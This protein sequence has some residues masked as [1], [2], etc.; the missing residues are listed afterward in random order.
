MKAL[1]LALAAFAAATA[2]ANAQIRVT[3]YSYKGLFGEYF[4]VSNLGASAVNITGYRFNDNSGTFSTGIALPSVTLSNRDTVIVTEVS[5]TVFDLVWFIE[6]G[7]GTSPSTLKGYV[8]NNTKN[9][10]KV[11]EIRIFNPIATL[12]DVVSITTVPDTEDHPAVLNAARTGW[13]FADLIAG[14]W[15]AGLPGAN[16]PVGNPGIVLP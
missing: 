14:S 11:D 1:S 16:G 15:K 7:F 4:E 9:L 10:G 5:A 3:E 12:I 2:A 8:A 13:V 6:P